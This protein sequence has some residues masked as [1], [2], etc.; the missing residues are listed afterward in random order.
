[1]KIY[2]GCTSTA[3]LQTRIIYIYIYI[4]IYLQIDIVIQNGVNKHQQVLNNTL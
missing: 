1:M 3:L 4:Y 2:I